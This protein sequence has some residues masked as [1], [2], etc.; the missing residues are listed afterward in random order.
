LVDKCG[1]TIDL[2]LS[3]SIP[4]LNVGYDFL[5]KI[6]FNFLANWTL[7][8]GIDISVNRPTGP[9]A[10][11]TA[12]TRHFGAGTYVPLTPG[13]PTYQGLVVNVGYSTPALPINV[14]I[15]LTEIELI[16]NSDA[17][18]PPQLPICIRKK[19]SQPTSKS[20]R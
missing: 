8:G 6:S 5:G 16:P 3:V 13:S 15:P 7:G 9:A 4:G 11:V 17:Y 12:G 19:P 1:N 14:Q 2:D 10:Q 20:E 18:V